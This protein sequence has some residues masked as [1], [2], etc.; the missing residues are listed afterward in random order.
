MSGSL[1][2]E[3]VHPY[4]IGC[5]TSALVYYFNNCGV[6][7]D[8]DSAFFSSVI[9]LG[10]IFAAF[11]ITIK[12]IILSNEEKMKVIT[13]SGYK[14][15]FLTYMTESTDSSLLLCVIGFLGFIKVIAD[16]SVFSSVVAGVFVFCLLALRRV[17][18][19]TVAVLKQDTREG[20]G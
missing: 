20:A 10:G 8:K 5:V 19:I 18:R 6:D 12:S 1:S 14:Q 16:L 15:V 9:T 2:W 3:R 11:T 4:V 13:N 7:F 17:T